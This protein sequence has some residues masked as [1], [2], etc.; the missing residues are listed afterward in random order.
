MPMGMSKRKINTTAYQHKQKSLTW[1]LQWQFPSQLAPV[2][3][4]EERVSEDVPLATLLDKY[5]KPTPE[6][7][8]IRAKLRP[9]TEGSRD[10][11][12]LLLRKEFVQ[13]PQSQYYRLDVTKV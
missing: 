2:E 9:Y 13:S 3:V 4:V 12:V 10:S 5:L 11:L 7:A 6:N 8:V 1:R